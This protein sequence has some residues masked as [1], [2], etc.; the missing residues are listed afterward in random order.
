MD[1]AGQ[2]G[3][4]AKLFTEVQCGRRTGH[5]SRT[6]RDFHKVDTDQEENVTSCPKSPRSPLSRATADLSSNA[7]LLRSSV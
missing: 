3:L 1:T 5:T 4:A 7:C 6:V 2:C